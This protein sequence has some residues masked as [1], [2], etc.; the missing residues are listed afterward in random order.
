MKSKLFNFGCPVIAVA[1]LV[2]GFSYTVSG[3][4]LGR[5]TNNPRSL[6]GLPPGDVVSRDSRP[7]SNIAWTA[8]TP[9]ADAAGLPIY[10]GSAE[11]HYYDPVSVRS[12]QVV[13]KTQ[14][15]VSALRDFYGATL[16]Q[17]GWVPFTV[18]DDLSR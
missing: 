13:Y 8:L 10:P 1:I 11:D 4:M 12:E 18:S 14:A 7:A 17:Q 6:Q 16:R 5:N 3:A 2:V 9:P 15:A